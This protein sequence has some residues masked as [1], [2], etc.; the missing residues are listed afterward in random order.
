MHCLDLVLVRIKKVRKDGA[1]VDSCACVPL[2]VSG[3]VGWMTASVMLFSCLLYLAMHIPARI[4]PN[5]RRSRR[6]AQKR[7][8]NSFCL[9]PSVPDGFCGKSLLGARVYALKHV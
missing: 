5:S 8:L 7:M 4:L 2:V 9:E 3:L 1:K 6:K